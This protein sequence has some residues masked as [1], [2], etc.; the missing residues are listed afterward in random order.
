MATYEG[1]VNGFPYYCQSDER[2][3]GIRYGGSG[4]NIGT[5]GCGPTSAAM[6]LKSYGFDVTPEDTASL[7]IKAM[8]GYATTSGGVC[9]PQLEKSPYNLSVENTHSIDAVKSALG[10]GIPV[11][12]NPHGPCDFTQGGHYI[13]LCGINGDEITVNDP[14]HYSMCKSRTWSSSYIKRCCVDVNLVD[15]F[16]IISKNGQGSIGKNSADGG[17]TP[18]KPQR[19]TVINVPAG[20]G[21]T[22]TYE[23]WN[24]TDHGYS[25]WSSGTKQK[26]LIE[27]SKSRGE[28][29]FDS[30]GYGYVGQRYVVAMTST[31]GE[32]GDYI[33]IYC[34]DGRVI[35]AV[36][37]DEKSQTYE[38]WDNN[39]ANKW[40]HNNGECIVEFMTNWAATPVHQNPPSNGG[41]IKVINL[42][43]YFEYPEYATGFD[44]GNISDTSGGVPITRTETISYVGEQVGLREN[45]FAGRRMANQDNIE[46]YI[47][48]P[49]TGKI[50]KPV[51]VNPVIWETRKWGYSQLSFDVVKDKYLDFQEGNQVI[52]KYNGQNVFC[53][54]VFDKSRS[55][56]TGA[57][58]GVIISVM[59]ADQL[60]YFENT[61]IY[62][63]D[64]ITASELLEG[65]CRDHSV[66]TGTI[67]DTVVKLPQTAEDNEPLI[68]IMERALTYTAKNGGIY[69]LL[70]DDFGSLMLMPQYWYRVPYALNN[71]V[72]EKVEYK[73]S[74]NDGTFNR[75]K[76]YRDNDQTGVREVYINDK[77]AEYPEWGVLQ[78]TAQIDEGVDGTQEAERI[79]KITANKTRSLSATKAFGDVRVKAGTCIYVDLNLGDIVQDGFME[80]K[81]AKH[82]FT[83][84][85]YS[86]DLELIGGQFI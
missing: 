27:T 77:S 82:S 29:S 21:K 81:S 51:V 16:W 7:F 66:K 34:A 44:G 8:G 74:I 30:D 58:D 40:G 38:A 24:R 6:I 35:N 13:V 42:G 32:V 80:V 3:S 36:I 10:R 79:V 48:N 43:N 54:Y 65:I 45:P 52:F 84:D 23:T 4:G 70:F 17:R 22:Y 20:L 46:L 33:D 19:E 53:G 26:K 9:F 37:G 28:Y 41:I 49:A 55:D 56:V 68:D 85:F 73:S 59:A 14:S 12:A 69:Y 15:G 1:T 60:R 11:V 62:V 57:E 67:T 39:P 18:L 72:C 76:L 86:M 83:G 50:M 47:S 31:F 61:D 78:Y 64:N 25:E 2:W 75:V 5:S 63:Y 71:H